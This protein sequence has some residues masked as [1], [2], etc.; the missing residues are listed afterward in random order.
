MQ[1][2]RQLQSLFVERRS[3]AEAFRRLGSALAP[4]RAHV[5]DTMGCDHELFE[6][7]S[8]RWM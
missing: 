1:I 6:N 4:F 2:L 8:G 3:V 5:K 7:T